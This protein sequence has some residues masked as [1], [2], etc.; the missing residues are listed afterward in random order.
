VVAV[1]SGLSWLI[2]VNLAIALYGAGLATLNLVRQRA[3]DKPNLHVECGFGYQPRA[4]DAA[5]DEV[6]SVITLEG[7]NTGHRQIEVQGAGFLSNGQRVETIPR[8]SVQP[9]PLPRLLGDGESVRI[10]YRTS[11]DV[12]PGRQMRADRV[13]IRAGGKTWEA[14]PPEWLR[15]LTLERKWPHG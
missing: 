7:R 4:E 12:P 14:T 1:S 3:R 11:G 15:P 10:H 13:Y 9:G 5:G 6:V 8:H 2:Y